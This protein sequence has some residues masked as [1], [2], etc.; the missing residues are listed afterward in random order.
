[1]RGRSLTDEVLKRLGD[2]RLAKIAVVLGVDQPAA[3][4]IVQDSVTPIATALADDAHRNRT[5]A[6]RVAGAINEAMP[7]SGGAATGGTRRGSALAGIKGGI[8][9]LVIRRVAGPAARRIA[10][11]TGIPVRVAVTL[12]EMLLPVVI[13]VL[14]KRLKARSAGKGVGAFDVSGAIATEAAVP[15]RPSRHGLAGLVDRVVAAVRR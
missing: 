12:A 13:G 6:T 11:K 3:R 4:R 15:Q 5:E 9:A 1:M 8:L 14:A 10:K 2:E 7:V